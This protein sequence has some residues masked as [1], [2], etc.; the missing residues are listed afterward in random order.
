MVTYD[1]AETELRRAVAAQY[2][3]FTLSPGYIWERGLSKFPLALGVLFSAADGSAAIKSAEAARQE[4][5]ANL[6]AAVAA[7]ESSITRA[8]AEYR[9]AWS[10]LRLVRGTLLPEASA[11]ARQADNQLTAGAIDRSDWS[12]AQLLVL[13]A[14]SDE[15][16]AVRQVL[17]AEAG[18]ETALRQPLSGPETAILLPPAQ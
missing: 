15:I 5:A 11:L 13:T 8:D 1:L 18:L 12:S 3:Q 16:E 17:V 9:S 10:R 2:P 7:V 14:R 6:E 4:A